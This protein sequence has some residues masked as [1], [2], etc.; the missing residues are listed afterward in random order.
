MEIWYL[1]NISSHGQIDL[2][3]NITCTFVWVSALSVRTSV[4]ALRVCASASTVQY[5][6]CPYVP[7]YLRGS[8]IFSQR[9]LINIWEAQSVVKLVWCSRARPLETLDGNQ[10][11]QQPLTQETYALHLFV[12]ASQFP[13][14]WI[15]SL[16]GSLRALNYYWNNK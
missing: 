7:I 3:I 1:Y 2:L 13:C 12:S 11:H 8:S 15:L 14:S 9:H 6:R 10:L 16:N 5:T 4:C